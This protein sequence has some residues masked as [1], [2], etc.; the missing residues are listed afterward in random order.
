MSTSVIEQP[1]VTTLPVVYSVSDAAIAER[2]ATRAMAAQV[3]ASAGA[4][5][6][7]AKTDAEKLAGR[8]EVKDGDGWHEAIGDQ[9]TCV[10]VDTGLMRKNEGDQVVE[11][12][13]RHQGIEL[14]VLQGWLVETQGPRGARMFS[15]GVE[16]PT[17]SD[18]LERWETAR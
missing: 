15:P 18:L 6:A 10:F 8:Q 2:D 9:L 5:L 3:I 13:E 11:T 12:F 16:P 1:D 17:P 4:A 7:S 14:A